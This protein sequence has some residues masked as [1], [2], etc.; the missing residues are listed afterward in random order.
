MNILFFTKSKPHTLNILKSLH[1]QGHQVL[2]VSKDAASFCDSDMYQWCNEHS[3]EYIDND[4]LYFRLHDGSLP[5]ID[6][7]ISNTFGKLIRKEILDY[8]DGNIINFHGAILP[9]Y[10]G[11]FG[12]NWGIFNQ[13]REWGVTAHFV[14]EEFDA[15]DII[16]IFRFKLDPG[17]ITVSELEEKSQAAA[18]E[19]TIKLVS[20]FAVSGKISGTPQSPGGHYYSRADFEKLKRVEPTDDSEVIARKIRACWCPPYEGAFIEQDGNRFELMDRKHGIPKS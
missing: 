20:Q 6:L 10:K 8:C 3:V 13:E 2:V 5:K 17:T 12:Y 14:N 15:G 19:L 11:V 1:D 18:E 4:T 16:D 9:D 7:G